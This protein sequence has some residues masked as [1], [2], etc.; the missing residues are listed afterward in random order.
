MVQYFPEIT[1]SLTINGSL[2]V[3]GPMSITGSIAGTSS[4]ASNALLLSGTGSVG[5][6]TTGAF[7]ATSSSLSSRTTQIESVYATTGSNSFRATQ[8]ITGSLTVTGQIIAQTLNVQQVTSSIVYSSGSNNFGCDLNSRQTFT[9]SVNITGSLTLVG[10]MTGSAAIFSCS[11]TATGLKTSGGSTFTQGELEFTSTTS[12]G[13]LGIF[14]NQP[15]TSTLFFDHRATNNT[16]NFVFRNGSG[17]AN[18]LMYISGNGNVG[19]ATSNPCTLLHTIIP[20]CWATNGTV[21]NSYPVAT[22][23]QCDC[24]GG[25]RGLQ[26]GV[27][28]GGINS[29]VFLK[30]NNTGARFSII[31]SSNCEN[32]TISSGNVGIGTNNPQV[33]LHIVKTS[34]SPRFDISTTDSYSTACSLYLA[35][36][37]N[38]STIEAYNYCAN[39][40]MNLSLNP[41]GGKVGIATTTPCTQL[42]VRKNFWQFWTEKSHGSN[43]ALF[44][45]GIPV[46]G[47]AIVQIAGSKY[48]P[49]ADNYI[50]FSTVYIRTNNVG[51]VQAFSCDSGTYQPSYYISGNTVY[52]CSIYAGSGTNYTGVAVSVQAS[53]HNNGSE[54][55]IVVYTL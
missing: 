42:Q 47:A 38:Y 51:A 31:D 24:A 15:S 5:F 40:G 32:F 16:G 25:A 9:G 22:F 54:A 46:F 11:V 27:P 41:S 45:V 14:T 43:V 10:N 20:T 6:A 52:F 29:P 30:V 23:S 39:V 3:S 26:I 37:G 21:A 49:G 2:S 33:L 1:G 17:G 34:G 28:T 36:S 8:S 35:Q 44:S 53:G 12:G 7:T 55:A 18:T 50:G 19:I 4:L 48:S 13:Q